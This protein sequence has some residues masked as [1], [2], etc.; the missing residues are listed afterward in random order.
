LGE[1]LQWQQ[2]LLQTLNMSILLFY[3][4]IV[5]EKLRI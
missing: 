1:D 4:Q 5:W 2:I 3:V